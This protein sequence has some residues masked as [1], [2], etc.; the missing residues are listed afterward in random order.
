MI[1]DSRIVQLKL[2][3]QFAVMREDN[4]KCKIV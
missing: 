3:S 4:R 1:W 2:Q